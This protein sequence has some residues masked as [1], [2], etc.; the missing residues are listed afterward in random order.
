[1]DVLYAQILT[2]GVAFLVTLY[3]TR[4]FISRFQAGGFVAKDMYKRERP[5]VPTMGGVP[6]MGGIMISLIAAQLLISQHEIVEKLLIFYFVVFIYG[7]FGLIDDLIKIKSRWKRVYLLYFLALPIA[8]LMQGEYIT[9]SEL[10]IRLYV[11]WLKPYVIAPIYVMVV[12][13]MINMHAGFNGLSGGLSWILMLFV[14]LKVL[15]RGD[16]TQLY[17]L[18]PI[19]GAL[20]AFMWYNKYPSR[21]FLGNSGTQM[22]GAAV[23]GLIIL[24]SLEIFGLIILLP[25]IINFLMWI[26]WLAN[27]HI[28]PHIKFAKLR[29]D[30]TI[31]PPNKLTMK[32]LVTHYLRVRE[33][34]AILILYAIT[35]AFGI[36]GLLLT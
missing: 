25:H 4:K 21:I 10:N 36:A 32:Y 7:I 18:M 2:F 8:L 1:M 12:S 6:L 22:L 13:N 34:R 16:T 9:F 11:G 31:E 17:Y 28:Y 35:A 14:G 15:L 29:D 23:G 19:F 5:D 26:Y 20:L 24:H 27:M 3:L 33:L 30:D